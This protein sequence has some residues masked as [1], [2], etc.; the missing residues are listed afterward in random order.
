[1]LKSSDPCTERAVCYLHL[2]VQVRITLVAHL[3]RETA[4]RA[5]DYIPRFRWSSTADSPISLLCTVLLRFLPYSGLKLLSSSSSP[6]AVASPPPSPSSLYGT[7]LVDP[8]LLLA[9][10]GGLSTC[11]GRGKGEAGLETVGVTSASSSSSFR[12]KCELDDVWRSGSRCD[13]V[14]RVE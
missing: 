5:D 9:R 6:A 13:C 12:T 1:M 11:A 8:A 3:E 14:V 2:Q 4:T 7:A 10:S